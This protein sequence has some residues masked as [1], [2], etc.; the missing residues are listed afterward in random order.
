ML[1]TIK[2]LICF[3]F[4]IDLGYIL[5]E[6]YGKLI[7]YQN[8]SFRLTSITIIMKIFSDANFVTKNYATFHYI[9]GKIFVK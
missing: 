4:F 5:N 9:N 3:L 6:K 2:S 7:S 1:F 8:L